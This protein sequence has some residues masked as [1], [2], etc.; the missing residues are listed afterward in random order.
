MLE[1]YDAFEDVMKF[2]CD[3]MGVI[4]IAKNHVQYNKTKHIDIFTI[5]LSEILFDHK[6][7]ALEHVSPKTQLPDIFTKALDTAHFEKLRAVLCV[8]LSDL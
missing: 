1:E 2:Y 7:I 6:I 4:S 3:N 8:C 5:T